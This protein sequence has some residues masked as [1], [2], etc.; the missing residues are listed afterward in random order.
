M[1]YSVLGG[2]IQ[3][4]GS[5]ARSPLGSRAWL[6]RV[7][8]HGAVRSAVWT[9]RTVSHRGIFA[10]MVGAVLFGATVAARDVR[11]RSYDL[12]GSVIEAGSTA[13]TSLTF[14][15]TTASVTAP[16]GAIGQNALSSLAQPG[17]TL[18]ASASLALQN[19]R[20]TVADAALLQQLR[21]QIV[22]P[23]PPTGLSG[24]ALS[25]L[26]SLVRQAQLA[27]SGGSGSGLSTS[28]PDK[29]AE[30]QAAIRDAQQQLI[31]ATTA[32]DVARLAAPSATAGSVRIPADPTL[33]R[34]AQ[35]RLSSAQARLKS[36]LSVATPDV[37]DAARKAVTAALAETP[38]APGGDQIVAANDAVD[39]AQRTYDG[40]RVRFSDTSPQFAD[41]KAKLD[42]A[43]AALV[44]IQRQMAYAADPESQP[45]VIDARRRLAQ[46]TAAPDPAAVASAQA[47]VSATQGQLDALLRGTVTSVA[48][49][50]PVRPDLSSAGARTVGASADPV[51]AAQQKLAEAQK[52]LQLIVNPPIDTISTASVSAAAGQTLTAGAGLTRNDLTAVQVELRAQYVM[53]LA[54]KSA[55]L[56]PSAVIP[57]AAADLQRTGSPASRALVWPVRGEVTQPFGVPELGVGAPHTGLDIAVPIATPVLAAASGVVSFAGGDPTTSYGYYAIVDHGAGVSTLYA[58]LALPA[59]LRPGQFLAQGGLVGLSGTTGF[60]TGP[61][62]HFEVRL[63]GV[64]VDPLKVL[65]SAGR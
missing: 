36:L 57:A 9:R 21:T 24:V 19:V 64:P 18:S 38:P 17:Y 3:V 49:T 48:S 56:H 62:V 55:R 1:R 31:D 27:S 52:A 20:L 40:V 30:A 41:A 22:A 2:A 54:L 32:S 10:V 5:S 43:K 4:T 47:V 50:S 29:L 46:L 33:V 23:A 45:S 37:I 61:H 7:A 26:V 13:Q 51:A 28:N 65:P 15:G 53:A 35:L 60:S 44:A 8:A 25:D 39:S 63:N 58:H 6:A 42:T 34:D 11:N 14:G 12:S 16:G 59:F